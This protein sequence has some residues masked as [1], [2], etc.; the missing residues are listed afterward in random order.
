MHKF[1]RAIG[2]S[3]IRKKDLEMIIN[4]IIECPEYMK[5]TK[6]SE[7]YE[8]AE[9]SKSFGNHIGI[10]VRGTYDEDDV[11]HVG[12]CYPYVEGEELSTDE[13]VEIE[14]YA[15]KESYA[16]ICDDIKVGVSLIFYLQNIIPYVKAKNSNNLPIR[17]TTLTLS[18][19]STQGKIMMPIRK[20]EKDRKKIKKASNKGG[21]IESL[22]MNSPSALPA[23]AIT[24][25]PPFPKGRT[26]KILRHA[27]IAAAQDDAGT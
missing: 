19:L 2:F 17:G 4:E 18:A 10:A 20:D 5:V 25:K 24:K 27:A 16:G 12:Y 15:E 11:F 21:D 3:D 23:G 6:D 13:S 14:K 26:H 22:C 8:F 1:L 9:L 7:G